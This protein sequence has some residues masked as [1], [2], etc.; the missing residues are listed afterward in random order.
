VLP[1]RPAKMIWFIVR[2]TKLRDCRLR[3][4]AQL[5]SEGIRQENC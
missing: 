3:H 2:F 1:A 4:L 5:T